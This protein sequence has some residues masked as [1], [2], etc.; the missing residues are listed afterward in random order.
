MRFTRGKSA[1]RYQPIV[2]LSTTEVVG[3]EA[4]MRWQHRERGWIPPNVFIPLGE[5]NELI[6]ELGAFALNSAVAPAEAAAMVGRVQS[7]KSCRS[8]TTT[9]A[10]IA[11]PGGPLR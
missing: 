6:L 10:P 2:D 3:F 1:L 9:A 11:R 8:A 4:L 5:R 7:V